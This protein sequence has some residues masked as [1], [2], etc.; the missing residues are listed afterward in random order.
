MKKGALSLFEWCQIEQKTQLLALYDCE[1]NLFSPSE[2]AFSSSKKYRF[3]CPI[4]GA[5]WE[6][7]TNKLTRM[8][9]SNYNVIKKRQEVT[10]CPYCKGERLSSQYNLAT[11]LPSVS[12][13]WDY[14]RNPHPPEKYFPSTHQ[15]FYFKCPHCHYAFLKPV[16]IKDRHGVFRC[17]NCGDGKQQEVTPFN[18]LKALYPQIAEELDEGRNEGITG[19]K[20]LPSY[21][22]KLWFKCPQG[23]HYQARLSNRTYLDRGCSICAQRHKTSFA[24]Q[25]IRFYLKKCEPNLQSCQTDPYTGKEVDILL[26]S[27][28]T[29]VEF[30]SCYCHTTIN[31]GSRTT[32]DLSKVYTLAQ[33][34]RVY[35]VLEKGTVLP[36]QEHPLV[37]IISAPVFSLSEKICQEYKELIYKLLQTLFPERE[38]YPNINIMRDQLLILQQYV[39]TTVKDS[40]EEKHPLLAADWH[41][42]KN[43]TLT[44]GMF[45]SNT[46]YK[47]YWICRNCENT[48]RMSMS[49]RLKV[50]PD[51]CRFCCHKSRYKSPLLCESYPFLKSFWNVSLNSI[52]FSQVSVASEKYGIFELVDGRI[53]SVRICNLSTWLDSHPN[54]R[55]EEYLERQWEKSKKSFHP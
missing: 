23:H 40:F 47:F 4:C 28:K 29:I 37:Q 50:N 36:V 15:K 51:T 3:R 32:A 11:E 52:P 8:K 33:Y 38:S 30:N 39:N 24:E 16:S 55:V 42:V 13:W 17:P 19:D 48:Y 6:Q 27:C 12:D 43:G 41:L 14:E 2:I 53:V 44:P 1:K 34:Y 21:N 20:I 46:I 54:N 25:A 22:G 45:R 31:D 35:I 9:A 18:C 5:S 49:N 10:F 26:P 7:T